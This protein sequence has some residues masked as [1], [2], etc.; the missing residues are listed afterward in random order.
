MEPTEPNLRAWEAAHRRRRDEPR[1]ALPEIVREWL[2]DLRGRHVLHLGCGSGEATAELVA[3]GALVTGLDRSAEALAAARQRVPAAA[4][5]HAEPHAPPPELLRGRFHLLYAG[6]RTLAGAA[7]L[8]AAAR[9]SLAALRAGGFLLLYDEHPV[10]AH[11]D[12]LFHWRGSY[13]GGGRGDARRPLGAVVTEIA[14]V[15]FVVRRLAELPA[16]G[17]G[18]HV[19][20]RFALVARKPA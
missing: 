6:E 10:R 8:S 11:V 19:P 4:L 12:A 18:P 1:T 5:V 15:G 7:D 16:P 2:P 14:Q 9:A 17:E 20:G 13:F 3:L